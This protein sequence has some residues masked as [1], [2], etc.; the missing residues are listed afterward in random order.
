M[1]EITNPVPEVEA[2]IV[3]VPSESVELA[4]APIFGDIITANTLVP[5]TPEHDAVEFEL[6]ALAAG[7]S[8]PLAHLTAEASIC[9]EAYHTGLNGLPHGPF[10]NLSPAQQ[11]GW[12][13]VAQRSLEAKES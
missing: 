4:A 12:R 13:A 1:N 11:S 3:D 9:Y 10:V 8:D 2:E 7:E 6:P 5:G